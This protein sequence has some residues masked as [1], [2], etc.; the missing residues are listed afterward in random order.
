MKQ[1]L[2]FLSIILAVSFGTAGSHNGSTINTQPPDTP[3][4]RKVFILELPFQALKPI[5]D[6][7]FTVFNALGS[8]L[9]HDDAK[10][11]NALGWRQFNRLINAL[12]V[13]SIQL[14]P[15]KKQK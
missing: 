13:D 8:A 1:F 6:S 5:E 4:Y 7:L 9:L 2:L 12:K 3:R 11:L 14:P 15:I 10:Y